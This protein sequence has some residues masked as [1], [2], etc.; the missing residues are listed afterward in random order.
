MQRG[1][2]YLQTCGFDCNN[3]AVLLRIIEFYQTTSLNIDHESSSTAGNQI[4]YPLAKRPISPDLARPLHKIRLRLQAGASR[5]FRPALIQPFSQLVYI[6][7]REAVDR[8]FDFN[9]C[10]HRGEIIKGKDECK[11]S[12]ISSKCLW[13]G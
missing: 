2:N 11:S 10:A 8:L 13:S 1:E 6:P 12:F 7:I 5:L 9:E 4:T 3:L